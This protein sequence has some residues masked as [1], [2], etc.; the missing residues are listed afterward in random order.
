MLWG[1]V[2]DFPS[3]GV[4]IFGFVA[5]PLTCFVPRCPFFED[6]RACRGEAVGEKKGRPSCQPPCVEWERNP[7]SCHQH[8][9]KNPC[10]QGTGRKG[11]PST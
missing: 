10:F 2:N 1:L 5:I 4:D 3:L 6:L 11:T 7:S 8:L 9:S